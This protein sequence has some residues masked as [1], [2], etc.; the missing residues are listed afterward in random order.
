[1]NKLAEAASHKRLSSNS[2]DL[3]I[4]VWYRCIFLA[5]LNKSIRCYY[6]LVRWQ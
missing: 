1:M 6:L 2:T 3:L 5:N 4:I